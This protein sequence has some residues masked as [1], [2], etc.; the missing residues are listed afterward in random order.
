MP[1]ILA[2]ENVELTIIKVLLD[3]E[4]KKHLQDMGIAINGKITIL[5]KGNGSVICIVKEGRVALDSNI[6]TKIFV[7]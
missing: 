1:L 5:S 6:A 3:D 2:P 7:K 4:L